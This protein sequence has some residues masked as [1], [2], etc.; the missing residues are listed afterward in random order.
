M[1]RLGVSD[2]V[3]GWWTLRLSGPEADS[4]I[5]F[6]ISKLGDPNE[7][8]VCTRGKAKARGKNFCSRSRP[9]FCLFLVLL[10]LFVFFFS[11]SRAGPRSSIVFFFFFFWTTYLHY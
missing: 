11:T 3:A 8:K 7:L 5:V 4:V 2:P 10:L 1:N 9:F 6:E